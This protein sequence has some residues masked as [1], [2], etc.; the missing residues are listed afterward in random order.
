MSILVRFTPADLTAEKY[1]ESVRK[2]EE[3]GG[4]PSP[5]GLEYHVCFGSDENLN[6]SEIW[7]SM[8]Q[9]E[10][11]GEKLMPILAE[12]GIQAGEP[13]FIDVYASVRP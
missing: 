2:L 4:W 6:V 13:Q 8:E 10:A 3:A 1:D 9:F 12:V 7:G 5:D 11:H